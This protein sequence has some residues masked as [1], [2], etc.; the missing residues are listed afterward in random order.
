M[1]MA[2]FDPAFI[3][4]VWLLIPRFINFQRGDT[5]AEE[6]VKTDPAQA[7]FAS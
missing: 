3:P 1:S 2:V 7:G 6:Q 5:V 4:A